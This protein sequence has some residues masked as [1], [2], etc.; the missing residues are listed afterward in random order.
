[1]ATW[2]RR[3]WK[4]TTNHL[5]EAVEEKDTELDLMGSDPRKPKFGTHWARRKADKTARETR[6]ETEATEDDIEDQLGWRHRQKE[7][8]KVQQLHYN[9]TRELAKKART[10][11]ML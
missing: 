1:M 5:S 6:G 11:M 10:T 8:R 4:R 2:G 9:G 7:R 3:S